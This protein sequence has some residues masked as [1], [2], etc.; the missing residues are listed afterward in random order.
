MISE[1]D[2]QTSQK[3]WDNFSGKF[4]L[5]TKFSE[6]RWNLPKKEIF[7][8]A[9]GNVIMVGAG[10]GNDF[11]SFPS[12]TRITAIDFSQKM[13]DIAKTKTKQSPSP[14]EL[15]HEDVQSLSFDDESFD[16]AITSCVFCSVPDPV[17]GLKEILRVLKPGGSLA[18]FEHT[19]S[20]NLF[21][22]FFLKTMNFFPGPDLTRKTAQNVHIAG[23]EILSVNY[24][25]QDIVKTIHARK[26]Q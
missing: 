1:K 7:S 26:P 3:F 10:T 24:I 21:F 18:M 19:D 13:L 9:S 12:D 14:V 5:L 22:H 8:K 6:W 11:K 23:F 20:K 15:K 16:S 25:F 2:N 17:K 4:N